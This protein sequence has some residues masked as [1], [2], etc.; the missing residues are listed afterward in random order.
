MSEVSLT[1][2]IKDFNLSIARKHTCDF[3]IFNIAFVSIFFMYFKLTPINAETQPIVILAFVPL[4]LLITLFR[5]I[6][7]NKNERILFTFWAVLLIYGLLSLIVFKVATNSVLLYSL[8]LLIM[9]LAYLLFLKNVHLLSP[10]SIKFCV[11]LLLATSL[12]AFFQIPGLYNLLIAVYSTFF[13]RYSFGAGTRGV[14]ILTTEPSYYVYFA[15]LLTYSID[16]LNSL[17]RISKNRSVFY[18]LIIFAMGIITKSAMVYLFL[19]IYIIQVLIRC[20]AN[21][22]MF[23]VLFFAVLILMP[24]A[25]VVLYNVSLPQ[26]TN[27][28]FIEAA[29]NV[30]Q[31]IKSEG[32]INTLF[33]A[34]ASGGFRILINVIYILSIFVYPLGTGF[35]GLTL[36]WFDIADRFGIDV[37]K[38]GHFLYSVEDN[39]P[40]DAQ[41]Y[42]PNLIGTIGIFA[43]LFVVFLYSGNKQKDRWLRYSIL[44]VVSLFFW[45]LQSNFFN[46]VFWVLI[47]IAKTKYS[48][49]GYK[50]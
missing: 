17:G 46:P 49:D 48:R 3:Y 26:G 44:F 31:S 24:V 21:K 4:V 33:F 32:L 1:R 39:E 2:D 18:K 16:Y 20:F 41:A 10:T 27:N 5:R 45:A 7:L 42:I 50:V 13:G 37:F 12:I 36:K 38:N 25:F 6:S 22:R 19:I 11:Y 34:D 43:L 14:C 40:L 28:R 35:G 29:S 8:R 23:W 30:L 9:P 47:A 15:V